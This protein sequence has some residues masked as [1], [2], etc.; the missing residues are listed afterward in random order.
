MQNPSQSMSIPFTGGLD[1]KTDDKSTPV[2][3]FRILENGVF[4]EHGSITKRWGY[5][6]FLPI[7]DDGTTLVTPLDCR[8]GTVCHCVSLAPS[9]TPMGLLLG[10]GIAMATSDQ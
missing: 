2:G 3:S 1:T 10:A 5:D 8:H 4:G 7:V 9:C 6:S